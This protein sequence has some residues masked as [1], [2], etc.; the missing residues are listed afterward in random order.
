MATFSS[1]AITPSLSLHP[2]RRFASLSS[3]T[4]LFFSSIV[5]SRARL[6]LAAVRPRAAKRRGMSCNCLFGLGVPEL[7]VI[8]GVA[9]LLFGPKKL[10]EV[11]KSIGKTV[12]SFQQAAKEF[13]TE[14]TK[15]GEPSPEASNEKPTTVSEEEKQE[16]KV[17]SAN[18]SS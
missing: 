16:D 13:E 8:A 4:S 1:A 10:P 11:G 12:K 5:C 3:S 15:D 9:A 17:P 14:L 7:V 18:G 2:P 6:G